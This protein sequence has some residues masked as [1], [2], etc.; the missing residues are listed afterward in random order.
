[1]GFADSIRMNS[2]RVMASTQAACNNIMVDLFTNVV[3]RT[4]VG[5]T[6]ME[7][8]P[9]L[10]KNNWFSSVG[11]YPSSAT[12][13]V[14]DAS[15]SDSLLNITVL[16]EADLFDKKDSVASFTNNISYAIRAERIGWDKPQWSGV[17]PYWMVATSLSVVANKNKGN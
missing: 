9:G 2:A 12:T 4:P 16:K 11:E 7:Q 5:A 8:H 15:G 6:A 10:L 1:M 14:Y 17:D 13:P 3:Q